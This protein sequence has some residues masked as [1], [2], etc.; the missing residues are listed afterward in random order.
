V[1]ATRASIGSA[2]WQQVKISRRRS[3][4][5][6]GG[7]I[8][9]LRRERGL[10]DRRAQRLEALEDRRLLAQGALTA[11]AVDRPV[12]GDAGD[13]GTGVGGDA[14]PG[15]ALQRGHEGLLHRLFGEL[16]IADHADQRRD[17]PSRLLPEG[18]VDDADTVASTNWSR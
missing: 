15:P 9:L 8:H 11:Q 7:V 18:A 13:P 17:R 2:G 14:V 12:A 4:R 10:V 3:S 16:E 6:L 5:Y 1:S